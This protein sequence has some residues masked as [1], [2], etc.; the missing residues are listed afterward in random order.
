MSDPI[1]ILDHKASIKFS[2]GQLRRLKA[3]ARARGMRLS[4]WARAVLLREA[5]SD[6]G[7]HLEAP[8]L[9][10]INR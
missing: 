8:T 1:P 7:G 9:P 4:S 5:G 3:V 10:G 2:A 6:A